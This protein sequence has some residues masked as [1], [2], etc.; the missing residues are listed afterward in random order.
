V[1]WNANVLERTAGQLE[2]PPTQGQQ[3]RLRQQKELKSLE[4][5]LRRLG[6]LW[7]LEVGKK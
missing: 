4:P 6:F 1:V 2:L 5:L 3:V 7:W